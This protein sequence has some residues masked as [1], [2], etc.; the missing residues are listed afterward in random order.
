VASG[1][2][3]LSDPW[4][5][6]V[7][8]DQRV[9]STL[10][11]DQ[12]NEVIV[13]VDR[14][15]AEANQARQKAGLLKR[16]F[17]KAK[18]PPLPPPAWAFEVVPLLRVLAEDAKKNSTIDVRADLRG[19]KCPDKQGAVYRL[20]GEGRVRHI[21]Q[22]VYLDPWLSLG[23]RLADGTR[24]SVD[25]TDRLRHRTVH[26]RSASGKHKTKVK[27][28]AARRVDVEVAGDAGEHELIVPTP[29]PRL[30]VYSKPEATRP[31][32]TA[33]LDHPLPP[34]GG[35]GA[36]LVLKAVA[37]VHRHF[38]PRSRGAA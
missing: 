32:A 10:P 23:A 19:P 24:V 2:D 26:K 5:R 1:A 13:L 15:G 31:T 11:A 7:A 8:L 20:Q 30:P 12:W 18:L 16:T 17:R 14:M 6:A 35:D 34:P 9:Q 38:R 36:R 21:D 37:E 27:E 28:K 29:P 33:R 22:A 3:V 25:I 4:Y